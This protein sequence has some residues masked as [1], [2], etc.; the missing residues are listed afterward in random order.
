MEN[1]EPES[2]QSSHDLPSN[3]NPTF[4]LTASSLVYLREVSKW[5]RFLGIVGLVGL[6]ISL[7]GYIILTIAVRANP[8]G[9]SGN[10]PSH[11]DVSSYTF[12]MTIPWLVVIIAYF[13]PIWWLYQ[14]ATKLRDALNLK[15]SNVLEESFLFLKK[16]Y[17]FMGILVIVL[18]AL[19]FLIFIIAMLSILS[20]ALGRFN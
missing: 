16:Q 17:K 2:E 10:F 5:G 6:G 8:F 9:R 18:I 13:F 19:Y 12:Y 20:G 15:N 14:F 3:S 11:I 4:T 1:F 7:I